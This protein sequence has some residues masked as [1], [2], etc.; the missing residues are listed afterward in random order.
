MTARHVLYKMMSLASWVAGAQDDLMTTR[1]L[2]LPAIARLVAAHENTTAR[3]PATATRWE[4]PA[5]RR[6][7]LGSIRAW[8]LSPEDTPSS[9]ALRSLDR[10]VPRR[11]RHV[12]TGV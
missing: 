5:R 11:C 10:D 7:R 9:I 1:R 6:L 2:P 8:L 3:T 4:R 12:S